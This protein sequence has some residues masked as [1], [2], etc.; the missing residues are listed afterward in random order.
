MVDYNNVLTQMNKAIDSFESNEGGY[1]SQDFLENDVEDALDI[2]KETDIG[3]TDEANSIIN[4][5][6][7]IV[8][9]DLIDESVLDDDVQKGQE[10]AEEIVEELYAL[11][12]E[13]VKAMESVKEN[14]NGMRYFIS[15]LES[16]FKD[17]DLSV[18][19]YDV[20][21]VLGL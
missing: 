9:I 3:Y 5:V 21:A 1:I 7:D 10:N 12:E 2:A 11:D 19:N 4:R 18:S 20:T 14:L 15:D 8:S 6:S 16:L 13:Q 17:G